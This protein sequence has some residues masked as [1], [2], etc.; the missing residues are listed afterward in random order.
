MFSVLYMCIHSLRMHFA[1]IICS[2][3]RSQNSKKIF[4]FSQNKGC[5]YVPC[6]PPGQRCNSLSTS[7]WT[8]FGT[9]LQ[10]FVYIRGTIQPVFGTP[11]AL[12]NVLRQ[13]RSVSTATW[14]D[15]SPPAVASCSADRPSGP[16]RARSGAQ[17]PQGETG[18]SLLRKREEEVI[19]ALRTVPCRM[20]S[21]NTL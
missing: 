8:H 6:G 2:S 10:L 18:A 21:L 17:D 12:T 14:T 3:Q 5:R 16:E 9:E 20:F 11:H 19:R 1:D 13:A 15:P 4:Y 7:H